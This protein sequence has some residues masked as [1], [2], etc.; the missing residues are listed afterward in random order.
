[1]KIEKLRYFGF[2]FVPITLLISRILR[3]AY[4]LQQEKGGLGGVGRQILRFVFAIEKLINPPFGTSV[5]M[6]AKKI[7]E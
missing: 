6:L 7:L 4:P 1:L 2:L 3:R 5:L